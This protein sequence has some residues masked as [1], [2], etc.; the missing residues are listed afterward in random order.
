MPP[1]VPCPRISGDATAAAAADVGAEAVFMCAEVEAQIPELDADDR[2]EFLSDLGLEISGL[3]RV[4]TA[5][6]RLLGLLTFFTASS[7]E[8]RAWTVRAGARA[9]RD[10]D[11]VA[12]GRLGPRPDQVERV[13]DIT[14]QGRDAGR[15][16]LGTGLVERGRHPVEQAG[17]VGRAPFASGRA[18][19]CAAL[20]ATQICGGEL[21]RGLRPGTGVAV[22]PCATDRSV[23]HSYSTTPAA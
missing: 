16:D 15:A 12:F 2:A 8:A 23:T 11:P 4:V 7:K 20:R 9:L 6:Y 5:A 14:A 3:V 19:R 1:I 13:D 18:G 22:L 21:R 10:S 17:R